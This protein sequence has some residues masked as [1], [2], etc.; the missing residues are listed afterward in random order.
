[1]FILRNRNVL[2]L[3]RYSATTLLTHLRGINIGSKDAD[4]YYDQCIK[5]F[6]K[7]RTDHTMQLMSLY[8]NTEDLTLKIHYLNLVLRYQ[9]LTNQLSNM[10]SL[11][12]ATMDQ[13]MPK[14]Y[15]IHNNTL[16]LV[17]TNLLLNDYLNPC[18]LI[19]KLAKYRGYS[20]SSRVYNLI[21]HK[22]FDNK[23]ED[24]S[25][26]EMCDWIWKKIIKEEFGTYV[27]TGTLLQI[28]SKLNNNSPRKFYLNQN[29]VHTKSSKLLIYSYFLDNL[30][31]SKAWEFMLLHQKDLTNYKANDFPKLIHNLSTK[32]QS[33]EHIRLELVTDR[34]FQVGNFLS[35]I[36]F[37]NMILK[38]LTSVRSENANQ[39]SITNIISFVNSVSKEY[40]IQL[41]RETLAYLA[42]ISVNENNV[43]PLTHFWMFDNYLNKISILPVLILNLIQNIINSKVK[44]LS[45]LKFLILL[46]KK[47]GYQLLEAYKTQIMNIID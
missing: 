35:N 36:L 21:I 25:N 38:S 9:I 10:F 46:L 16:E 47:G 39:Q 26:G 31:T 44:D 22:F 32:Y 23:Y 29:T 1:M 2:L 6:Q 27:S 30:E 8:A 33:L 37:L 18:F 28:S 24:T 5:K 12:I 14:S 40:N 17:I 4:R 7:D 20:F 11:V 42:E 45:S 41:N 19:L 34:F 43:V 15:C 3:R 13:L